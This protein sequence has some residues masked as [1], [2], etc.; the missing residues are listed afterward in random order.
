M[1]YIVTIVKQSQTISG[2]GIK[3]PGSWAKLS[4]EAIN[5]P[6][7]ES[8]QLS[9]ASVVCHFREVLRTMVAWRGVQGS[10]AVGLTV[11]FDNILLVSCWRLRYWEAALFISIQFCKLCI[12]WL[13]KGF[14]QSQLHCFLTVIRSFSSGIYDSSYSIMMLCTVIWWHSDKYSSV[15]KIYSEK[16][17]KLHTESKQPVNPLMFRLVHNLHFSIK[18]SNMHVNARRIWDEFS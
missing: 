17:N 2:S 7:V 4:L 15:C 14:K 11:S 1:W 16:L 18:A 6:F 9:E 10:K 12:E 3:V 13:S 8:V 5:L